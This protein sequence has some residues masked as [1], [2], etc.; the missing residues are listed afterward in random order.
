V[1]CISVIWPKCGFSS[2]I[3]RN[4]TSKSYDVITIM[5]PKNVIKNNVTN[6][7]PICLS[8]QNFWLRQWRELYSTSN[9]I[10]QKTI[11]V[12]AMDL[13]KKGKVQIP[14]VILIT[15][16]VSFLTLKWWN[17]NAVVSK[18]VIS[19]HWKYTKFPTLGCV[20]YRFALKR[21]TVV[22]CQ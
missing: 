8:N 3:W 18:T 22:E 4:R 11:V 21:S 12:K 13:L 6:F 14:N 2:L 9:L 5:S 17:R 10:S 15:A 20:L 7:I 1:I 16:A 19:C